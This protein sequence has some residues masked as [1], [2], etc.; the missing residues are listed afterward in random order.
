MKIDL[1][2]DTVTKPTPA[3]LEAMF[4]ATVGDDVFGDDPTVN[5]LQEKAARLFGTEAALFCT[6]GTLTNQL[7]IRVHTQP[8]SEV[9]CDKRSHVYLYEGGGIALNALSSVKLLD[10][11]RGKITAQQ[12]QDA[13]N[14]DDIHAPISRLVVLENTMNKGGGC[15]YTEAEIAP[16]R[17]L[18]QARGLALHLDGARLFNALVETHETPAQ[19]GALFDSMSICLS[20]G[21]GCPV[22][23]LLLGS[24]DFIKKAVRFRKAMGGGWRQAGYLAAAGLYALDHHVQRLRDDH[25]RARAIGKILEKRPEVVAIYP[26]ETN[27]VIFELPPSILAADYVAQLATKGILAVTFGKHLVR[28]VT[29][30]DFTDQHL[31]AFTKMLDAGLRQISKF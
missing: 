29:H 4:S 20:K 10:G 18:C 22:G 25:A 8:G 24:H 5:A 31:E 21:L 14:A 7:A 3:M 12:V 15:Y 19:H 11:Q 9:I 1:R 26:I 6:S 16:I 28:F 2:S 13:I 23:S 27:I 30:L 17:A